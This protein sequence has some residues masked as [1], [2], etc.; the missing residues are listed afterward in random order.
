MNLI[1]NRHHRPY[2]R[3][4]WEDEGYE[5]FNEIADSTPLFL[6][7]DYS[8]ALHKSGWEHVMTTDDGEVMDM[9]FRRSVSVKKSGR[10]MW[11]RRL[12]NIFSRK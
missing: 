8:F 3:I 12:F 10:N 5:Y 4:H 7:S 11:L 1:L 2:L 9:L 6:V